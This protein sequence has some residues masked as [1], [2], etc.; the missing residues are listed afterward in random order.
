MGRFGT[1]DPE[2]ASRVVA[3]ALA[4]PNVQLV[5]LMTHFATADE[6]GDSFFEEQLERFERWARPLKQAHPE[7]LVH[8][9]NSAATLR[10][11]R[12]HFDMVRC[13]IALYGMD[14]FGQDPLPAR[15][16]PALELRS[17]LAEV[18]RA[19][20]GRARAMDGTSRPIGHVSGSAADRL[21]RRLAP[22]AVQQ[23]RGA[24]RRPPPPAGG[25]GEHG[26]HRRGPRRR[27]LRRSGCCER[28]RC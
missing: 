14:P 23:R 3:A 26:Q 13:G 17:H 4:A 10:D 16:E 6:P 25:D 2:E 9:A 18:K 15:L 27:S 12:A 21:R 8:A 24:D 7:V 20:R 1:R 11:R 22:R 19:R 28:T 5:G